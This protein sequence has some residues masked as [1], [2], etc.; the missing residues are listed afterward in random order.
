MKSKY[1][2]LVIDA[3]NI[4]TGG[5]LT[6]LLEFLNHLDITNTYFNEV[7]V[8]A[9]SATLDRIKINKPWLSLRSHHYIDNSSF[10]KKVLFKIYLKRHV[11]NKEDVLFL[12][13]TDFGFHK[14]KITMFQNLLP[15][16]FRES[17]RL[18]FS[19]D[20]IRLLVL[21][22]LHTLNY[23][24]ADGVIVLNSYCESVLIR[25]LSLIK[26]V[27]TKIIPHGV[28]EIF[29]RRDDDDLDVHTNELNLIY[30]SII[31]QYK[32]QLEIAKAVNE[33]SKEGVKVKLTL[34]GPNNSNGLKGLKKHLSSNVTYLGEIPYEQ[35]N[36]LYRSADI[37]I[38]GSTCET[39][40]M[41]LLEAMSSGIPLLCSSYS[42][43][44]DTL[45][46]NAVYFNPL[47][48]SSIKQAIK[49]GKEYKGVM[50]D[51]KFN[52]YKYVSEFSWE[53]CAETTIQ[54]LNQF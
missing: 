39:F 42:S 38:W 2:K 18:G 51:K 11:L 48:Q 37:L 23:I 15:L 5:G 24:L 53:K 36:K 49:Y 43:M 27:N 33:L 31:S 20:F 3:N 34:V 22:Y 19:K 7:I 47:N 26:S 12:P 46:E 50:F 25:K 16:Q 9:P 30:V 8:Y 10:F 1:R 21:R 45:K 14:K 54:Y 6:H 40:G 13:G 4:K 41:I 17:L 35:L 29:K 44:P 52:G 28:S 32:H